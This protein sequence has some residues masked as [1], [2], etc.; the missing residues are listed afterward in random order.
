MKIDIQNH[1]ERAAQA[2]EENETVPQI[3]TLTR[4]GR[5]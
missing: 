2:I 5:P 3:G 1:F 4:I